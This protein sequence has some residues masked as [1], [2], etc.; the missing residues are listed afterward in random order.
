[1]PRQI[2]TL[3]ELKE[4]S[5]G[6]ICELFIHLNFG[7]RSGKSV[8]WMPGKGKF[9]ILNESDGIDQELTCKPV[10]Y[11]VAKRAP[12]YKIPLNLLNS[13]PC[14]I[15]IVDTI[16]EGGKNEHKDSAVGQ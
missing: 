9:W 2:K 14:S 15:L 8:E 7:L 4:L 1:M 13:P 11:R 10:A 16:N 5:T 12:I 3:E 6:R